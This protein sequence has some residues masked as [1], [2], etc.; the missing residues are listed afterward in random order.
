VN[1]SFV[2]AAVAV[3]MTVERSVGDRDTATIGLGASWKLDQSTSL[4]LGAE[5]RGNREYG[6]DYRYN[7]SV[8]VRF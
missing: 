3:P 5:W 4:R 1:A 2:G 8:N 6:K 7:A